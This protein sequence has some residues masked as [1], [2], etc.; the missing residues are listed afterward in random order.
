VVLKLCGWGFKKSD[1]S[2]GLDV[3]VPGDGPTPLGRHS[4]T[5]RAM[6]C[7]GAAGFIYG[8]V[9]RFGKEF[10]DSSRRLLRGFRGC[11]GEVGPSF[12]A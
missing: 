6:N 7:G 9:S 5:P 2:G 3:A 4:G 10:K 1:D 8:D 11:E 12:L